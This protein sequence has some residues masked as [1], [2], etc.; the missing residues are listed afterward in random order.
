MALVKKDEDKKCMICTFEYENGE[1]ILT[2]PCFH[3]YHK[4]CL[5]NW[6]KRQ[7]FCPIDRIPIDVDIVVEYDEEVDDE[8]VDKVD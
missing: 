8:P 4:E 6:L 5:A 7:N 2:T 1:E 3:V